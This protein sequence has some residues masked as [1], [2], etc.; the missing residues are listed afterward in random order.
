MH[1]SYKFFEEKNNHVISCLW[2]NPDS[3]ADIQL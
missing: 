1:E 2:N 3:I